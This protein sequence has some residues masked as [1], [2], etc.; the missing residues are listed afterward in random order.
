MSQT[1]TFKKGQ[2]VKFQARS[3]SGLGKIAAIRTSE[4]GLWYDIKTNDGRE[5]SLRAAN[6]KAV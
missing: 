1:S 4:R 2:Q 6:L 3:S 5:I